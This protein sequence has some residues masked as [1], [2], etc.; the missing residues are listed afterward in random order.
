MFGY[1]GM[2]NYGDEMLLK[3][4]LKLF[5]ELGLKE[6]DLLYPRRGSR[7]M[8]GIRIN[9]VPRTSPLSLISA[10]KKADIVLGGGGN[11]FQDETSNRSFLYYYI[12]VSTA[13]FFKKPVFLFGHGIGKISSRKNYSRMKKILSKELC[14]GFFRDEVS[15]RYA[16]NFGRQHKRGTDLSYEFL[17]KRG[18]TKK[19]NGRLGLFLKRDWVDSDEII[20]PLKDEGIKEIQILVAFPDEELKVAKRAKKDLERHFPTA[21]KVGEVS[22]LT[23]QVATCSLVI[24]ER[25]HGSIVSSHF[26][27]P[28][29]CSDTFKM[30]SYFKDMKGFDAFF[31]DKSISEIGHALSKIRKIDYGKLNEGF[32]RRN[33][34]R[35]KAMK[36]WLQAEIKKRPTH[37]Q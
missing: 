16:R 36:K 5:S 13:L 7:K 28:L 8:G 11:L 22:E 21:I 29:L 1:Y 31:K 3:S 15:Y 9:H 6:V 32:L 2:N 10:I 25:L 30:K 19:I 33:Q 17:K 26:G 20:R 14:V 12:L 37:K 18:V 4:T 24:S 34:A 27:I 23:D 35:L